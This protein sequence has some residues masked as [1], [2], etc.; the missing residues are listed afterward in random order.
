MGGADGFAKLRRLADLL[1]GRSCVTRA[2]VQNGWGG[3]ELLV[4]QSGAIAR[5]EVCLAFGVS[6]AAAFMAGVEKARLLLAVNT[7]PDAP[8]FQYADYGLVAD[9]AKTLDALLD[10]AERG[11]CDV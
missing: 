2:A 5:P 11:G 8:I 6:G 10:W 1:G 7:D 9:A 4:G 3:M